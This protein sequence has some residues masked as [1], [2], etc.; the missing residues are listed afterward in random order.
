MSDKEQSQIRVSEFTGIFNRFSTWHVP[1]VLF[2]VT[3]VNF[4][5]CWALFGNDTWMEFQSAYTF[6]AI[7]LQFITVVII[8]GM[9]GYPISFIYE[10]FAVLYSLKRVYPDAPSWRDALV[11]LVEDGL[12]C[13]MISEIPGAVKAHMTPQQIQNIKESL[14]T[15][16]LE[17]DEELISVAVDDVKENIIGQYFG[18]I[19]YKTI[20]L[21]GTEG[22]TATAEFVGTYEPIRK[23]TED[24]FN[25]AKAQGHTKEGVTASDVVNAPVTSAYFHRTKDEI[26]FTNGLKY[27]IVQFN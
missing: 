4:F 15:S 10:A 5:I 27:K 14:Q 26:I 13:G 22:S 1:I 19:I 12:M 25:D 6:W 17:K 7:V 8:T 23:F 18:S 11:M 9:V 16:E 21:I 20:T 3:C 2:L 24:H